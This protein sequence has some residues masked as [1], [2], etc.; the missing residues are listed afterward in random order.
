MLGFPEKSLRDPEPDHGTDVGRLAD[1]LEGSITFADKELTRYDVIDT[2]RENYAA[3]SQD[4]A[5]AAVSEAWSELR[6]RRKCLGAA[7]TYAVEHSVLVREIPWSESPAYAFCLLLAL[8][9]F[10]RSAI[11]VH[12]D[13]PGQ[14]QLF[15]RMTALALEQLGWEVY[16]VGWSKEDTVPLQDRVNRLAE[17][18]GEP[19]RI[20]G[21]KKWSTFRAKDKGLDVV[22][23]LPFPDRRPGR[24]VL[25]VQCASGEDWEDKRHTPDLATWKEFIEFTTDPARGLSMPFVVRNE[26]SFRRAAKHDGLMLLLDRHRLMV[27]HRPPSDWL[28]PALAADLVVWVEARVESLV[29]TA[30]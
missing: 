14:G 24:P 10:Y 19:P 13:Y 5:D 20:D 1:W 28:T 3:V 16:P 15:E 4:Q 11:K 7:A 30:A 25:L 21:V 27:P 12:E 9:P 29:A 26:S 22:C 17:K 2:L 23:A 6:H 8:Q 18:L